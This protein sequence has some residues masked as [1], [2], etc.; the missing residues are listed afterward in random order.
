[1]MRTMEAAVRF[2]KPVLI[3]NVGPELDP[4][5]DPILLRQIFVQGGTKVIKL[6]DITVPYD[7]LFR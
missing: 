6:G 1:M 2:G 4:S 3:E 7:D 5:L